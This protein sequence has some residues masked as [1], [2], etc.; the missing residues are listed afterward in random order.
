MSMDKNNLPLI[1]IITPCYNAAQY[2]EETIMSI[3]QQTVSDWE[4]IIIDDASHDTSV[5]IIKKIIAKD[6]R[7]KLIEREKNEGAGYARNEGLRIARG[8]YIAFLDS[9]DVWLSDKLEK[10]INFMQ[11]YDYAF[12]HTAFRRIYLKDFKVVK[13]IDV[14]V[15]Q[16]SSYHQLLKKNTIG[17]LTVMIDTQKTGPIQMVNMRRRQDYALWLELTRRGFS[18]HG[19]NE[20]LAKYRVRNDSI[21]SNK[22]T[23]AK[24]NWRV[25]RETEGL[26]LPVSIWYFM[27]YIVLKTL[28]YKNY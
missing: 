7:I 26:S 22:F 25:Y 28:E 13:E 16:S 12:T 21:S 23:V 14:Q 19:L 17:C 18:A 6:K 1:S 27:H 9:D 8:R 20:V 10:Q 4:L 24:Q 11:K 2:I 5:E 15:P 3:C